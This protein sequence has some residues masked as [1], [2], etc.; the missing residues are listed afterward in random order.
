MQWNKEVDV[1]ISVTFNEAE[2]RWLKELVKNPIGTD[3][4]LLPEADQAHRVK[5]FEILTEALKGMPMSSGV[6]ELP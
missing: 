4:G 3:M 1:K 2:A 6:V 5:L